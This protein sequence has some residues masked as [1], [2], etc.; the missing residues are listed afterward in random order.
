[1]KLWLTRCHGGR[2]IVTY[3]KPIIQRIFGTR[4]FDAFE[5]PGEPV[6]VRHLCEGGIESLLGHVPEPLTPVRIELTARYLSE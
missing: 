1:M 6:G 2:C 5:H 4:N 3:H